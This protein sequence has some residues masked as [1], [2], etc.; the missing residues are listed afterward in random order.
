MLPSKLGNKSEL[1]DVMASLSG[2]VIEPV[3]GDTT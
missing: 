2:K 3:R 1:D